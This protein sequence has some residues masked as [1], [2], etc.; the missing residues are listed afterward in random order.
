MRKLSRI[1]AVMI[2]PLVCLSL[3]GVSQN[4]IIV[5]A[6]QPGSIIDKA[7]YGQFTEH[8]G[9]CIYGGI[10]VG[11][12][13]D[14][15]NIRGYRTDVVNALKDMKVSLVRWP[16]GCFADTYHWKDG[17][18]PKADRPSIINVHW[19]GLT[20]DNSF[21]T[22]EFL[23]FC[24]LIG[25]DPYISLNVGS[26]TIQE[27]ADWIEYVTSSNDSPMTKLRKKNGREKPWNVKYWAAGNETWGCGG[28]MR[29]EYYADLYR[30]Y[31]SFMRA[32]GIYKIA[33]G[34]SDFNYN[35]TE[36]LMR[37]AAPMMNGLSLHYYTLP[38]DWNKK[39][40]ATQFNDSIWFV[41]LQKTLKME[42]FVTKHSAVMDKYDPSKKVGLLVD[43]WGTWYDAEPGTNPGFLI[44]QNTLRDALVAGINLNI[45][46]NHADR[47]RMSNIAQMINVLQ[48]V[49][50]TKDKEMVL[51]PTY[52]VFKMYNVHQDAK[53]LPIEIKCNRYTSGAESIDAINASASMKDGVVS[54]TLCNLDPA[55][56]QAISFDVQGMKIASVAGQIITANKINALNDFG[57]KEEVTLADFKNAKLNKGQ[58]EATIP[59]KS[60]V[61]IQLK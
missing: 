2:L 50:Q 26:G 10:Y 33:S 23:D 60:V 54:I 7:I 57:K 58:V 17:I 25:A 53:M 9:H 30:Q 49:I 12:K 56:S 27:A 38:G 51:T 14:I 46:N 13:S 55:N 24:E 39:G 31:A 44:Q 34:A 18:G 42:E 22:H 59:A 41:T 36:V 20:E 16:G 61:L 28:N 6:D 21:G 52:Y 32:P 29:P 3:S 35:W 4:K 11:E 1:L 5:H 48:A 40:S 19:G 47:V 37:E 15:P 43:E 8:L 45:F